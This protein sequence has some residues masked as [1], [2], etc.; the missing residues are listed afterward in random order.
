MKVHKMYC[1]QCETMNEDS[2]AFCKQCDTPLHA[3]QAGS[4]QAV[5]PNDIPH[6]QPVT[7]QNVIQQGVPVKKSAKKKGILIAS[8]VC[9]TL[10]ACMA[11]VFSVRA[12]FRF[13]SDRNV[14][15]RQEAN[16]EQETET[17]QLTGRSAPGKAHA[18]DTGAGPALLRGT[19]ATVNKSGGLKLKRVRLGDTPM[20][21][22]GTYT[23]FVYMCGSDLESDAGLATADLH[24]MISASAR[25]NVRFIIQTGGAAAWKNNV[26]KTGE[27]GRYAIYGGKMYALGSQSDASMGDADTLSAFLEWGI[28][29]APAAK[30]GVVFWDHGGGSIV[31]VCADRV[32]HDMLTLAEIDSALAKVSEKMTDK[33][34]FIGFDAC[35]MASVECANILS[36]YAEYMYAS[37]EIEPGYGWDYTAIG[38]YL[39]QNPNAQGDAL[40][41]KVSDSYYAQNPKRIVTF[42]VTD[43]SKIDNLVI[44]LNNYAKEL[45]AVS[46]D[47]KTFSMVVRGIWEADNFGNNNAE[48]GYTNMVD[49]AGIVHA[50]A[51]YAAGAQDVLNAIDQ[52]VVYSINGGEH[53]DACGLSTY[54]PL[55]IAPNEINTFNNIA[56]CPYYMAFAS[57]TAYAI[58]H[59]GDISGYDENEVVNVWAQI[60][61][62][63]KPSAKAEHYWDVYEDTQITGN[64]SLFQ[65]EIEPSY[66]KFG[67]SGEAKFGFLLTEASYYNLASISTHAWKYLPEEKI[68]LDLG[69]R[70]AGWLKNFWDDVVTC[71]AT[72]GYHTQYL[73]DGQPFPQYK[74]I[75]N[76]YDNFYFDTS[77][78]ITPV[79]LNGEPTYLLSGKNIGG[80]Q[81][82]ADGSPAMT[83]IIP[84]DFI[85][86]TWAGVSEDGTIE[87]SQVVEVHARDII[88]PIY[89][90]INL[91]TEESFEYYGEEYEIP[92]PW[93]SGVFDC[94]KERGKTVDGKL[95]EYIVYNFI[96]TDLYGDTYE[97]CYR[98]YKK[99]TSI[100]HDE[101]GKPTGYQTTREHVSMFD[102]LY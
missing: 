80:N 40:G 69:I 12:G 31:G 4:E 100:G 77:V 22:A 27:L 88:T 14:G 76:K 73:M 6:A 53:T 86:G 5:S 55:A 67:S 42:S 54:Y 56:V 35:L 25:D 93:F 58:E 52:A 19:Y 1:K 102:T 75:G 47:Y 26:V 8:V 61:G 83:G 43:L 74:L 18:E 16:K 94:L 23:I 21:S 85:W 39:G 29:Y 20:G 34:E 9:G 87:R 50:G 32:S 89:H 79:L 66:R 49:L 30:M 78:Y 46:R 72:G 91:E 45:N 90:A 95:E 24:E 101:S 71:N 7:R 38:T 3:Q 84:A 92:I 64:S 68:L 37:Q 13:S 36:P 62:E 60:W 99:T 11:N 28:D 65:F 10:L 70:D 81:T 97:T 57:R 59:K 82:Y 96:L 17:I 41:K 98:M 15:Q 44:C 63:E 48:A 51:D 2:A 33:F